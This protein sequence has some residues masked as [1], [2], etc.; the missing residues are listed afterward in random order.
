MEHAKLILKDKEYSLPLFEGSEGEIGID[1]TKLRDQSGA[2]T[3]DPG[4]GNTGSCKSAVTFIDGDKGILH[5]RGY[6]IEELAAKSSFIEVCYLLIYG[7]LPNQSELEG[8]KHDLSNHSLINEDMKKMYE[9]FPPTAHPMCMIGSMIMSLS[10]FYPENGWKTDLE[11]NSIRIIAK[12]KTMAAFAYKRLVGLPYVYPRNN[13]SYVADLLHMLHAVP[14]EEYEVNPIIEDALDKVLILHADHEQ[15]CSAST[16][17]IAGSSHTSLFSSI[18]AGV[19]ALWGGLHGG[20]NQEVIEMLEHIR[21]DNCD[22]KKYVN[23]AKDKNS[24][25]KLMGFWSQGI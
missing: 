3:Y 5:Y 20:A 8:F 4:Y 22:Y 21:Q 6:P 2:I 25:F 14:T 9:A 18:A 17:R 23:L 7:K 19:S 12:I 16:V 15:N 24:N 11:L 13:L 10:A 1:I